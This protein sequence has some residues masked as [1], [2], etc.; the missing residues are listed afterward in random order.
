MYD[1]I[2]LVIY[3]D[4]NLVKGVGSKAFEYL[5]KLDLY[6]VED[7][8]LYYPYR[9]NFIKVIPLTEALEDETVTVRDRTTC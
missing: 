2:L 9:Y 6:K 7:L 8:I 4:I 5:S 3:M 1:I